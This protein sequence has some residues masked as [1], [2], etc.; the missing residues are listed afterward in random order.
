MRTNDTAG[1]LVGARTQSRN[2]HAQHGRGVGYGRRARQHER[3]A[4]PLPPQHLGL[5]ADSAFVVVLQV[6]RNCSVLPSCSV[7]PRLGSGT[8][9]P[10]TVGVQIAVAVEQRSNRR[11]RQPYRGRPDS[12]RTRIFLPFCDGLR[13][14]RWSRSSSPLE[15]SQVYIGESPKEMGAVGCGNSRRG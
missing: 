3:L 5:P 4:H 11:Y 1:S 12:R 10:Q 9:A 6:S 14:V 2:E 8:A 15:P 13:V 7:L